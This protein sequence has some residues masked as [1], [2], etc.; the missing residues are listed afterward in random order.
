M[1]GLITIEAI[2]ELEHVVMIFFLP[3]TS[4]AATYC[5]KSNVISKSWPK[6]KVCLLSNSCSK[7][8]KLLVIVILLFLINLVELGNLIA[9][10]HLIESIK[11]T[12]TLDLIELVKWVTSIDSIKLVRI[13][14]TG[15]FG[16]LIFSIRIKPP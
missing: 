12:T 16:R 11:S 4:L 5:F 8:K 10:V 3:N 14:S 15:R 13:N 6:V 2:T 9:S 1:Q 7:T